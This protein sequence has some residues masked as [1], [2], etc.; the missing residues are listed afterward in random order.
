MGHRQKSRNQA[1]SGEQYLKHKEDIKE[2]AGTKPHEVTGITG[3]R[4]QQENTE[5]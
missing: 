1:R 4:E 3:T 5:A 2:K